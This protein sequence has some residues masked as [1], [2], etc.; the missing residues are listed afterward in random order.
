MTNPMDLVDAAALLSDAEQMHAYVASGRQLKH[1]S[2]EQLLE[3]WQRVMRAIAEDP[4]SILLWR[5]E[6]DVR[7]EAE[8]RGA[9][10]REEITKPA[11]EKIL[12]RL[13]ATALQ[14]IN[15]PASRQRLEQKL[16]EQLAHTKA[17]L[18]S[19]TKN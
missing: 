10:L 9:P 4:S 7:H 2:N 17:Q 5:A 19:A 14:V 8:V 11:L 15:D 13:R 3:K 18:D 6:S 12:E 16:Q 1:L